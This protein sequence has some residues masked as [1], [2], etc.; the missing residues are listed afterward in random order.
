MGRNNYFQFKQFRIEQ[1]RSAMKVGIDG[2]LLGAWAD[3]GDCNTILDIGTGTGLIALMLAQ[4]SQARI[5]AIEIE[6]NAAEEATENV[7]ASPW[8]D[9]VEVANVSLQ[10]FAAET[11]SKFD[12]IVSNPPFFQN[13]LKA[14]NESR[15]LARHTDS[16]SYET[17]V[18]STSQ[19]LSEKG[20]FAF[21]FP[22]TASMEIEK[23]A[24]QN[25]LYIRRITRIA[26][27]EKKPANRILMEMSK[28]ETATV[29]DDLVIYNNDGSCSD[30]FKTLTRDYYLNF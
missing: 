12:L 9:R 1:A 25:Q 20:R 13:S 14:D 7:A 10:N 28:K 24:Q 8:K 27:N 23:L 3:V 21:I 26:P 11:T 6:K 22:E 16:L 5:T 18:Q 17:L 30:N 19:L 4:R 2:I 15:S 29:T